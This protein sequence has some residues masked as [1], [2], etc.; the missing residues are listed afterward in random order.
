MSLEI[1]YHGILA[2]AAGCQQETVDHLATVS[3][4]RKSLVNN[5]PGLKKLSFIFAINERI[6]HND[7]GLNRGDRVTLIPPMPGG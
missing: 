7:T 4:L 6:G 5:H 2:E 1:M 3:L